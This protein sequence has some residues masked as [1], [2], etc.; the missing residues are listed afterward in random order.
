MD[1]RTITIRVPTRDHT[2]HPVRRRRRRRRLHPWV[3]LCATVVTVLGILLISLLQPD[4]S[5]VAVITSVDP[6]QPTEQSGAY[7]QYYSA[8]TERAGTDGTVTTYDASAAYVDAAGTVATYNSSLV[9]EVDNIIIGSNTTTRELTDA[10]YVVNITH[11]L[12]T[13]F[14]DLIAF[15]SDKGV[16][17]L[18]SPDAYVATKIKLQN[19]CMHVNHENGQLLYGAVG[20]AITVRDFYT[21]H[22][23]EPLNRT[24]WD[25]TTTRDKPAYIDIML[26]KNSDVQ[27]YFAGGDVP[28]QYVQ[29]KVT[30]CKAHTAP[31]GIAQTYFQF[32]VTDGDNMYLYESS[33]GT[34]SAIGDAVAITGNGAEDLSNLLATANTL[35]ENKQYW[36]PTLTATNPR[37]T[38]GISTYAQTYE[39]HHTTAKGNAANVFELYSSAAIADALKERFGDYSVVGVLV[40]AE[41]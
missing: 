9:N 20:P 29:F 33:G 17:G 24:F 26:V 12:T 28:T 3:A 6:S 2:E 14:S 35:G 27:S 21:E 19:M 25:L 38:L 37:D 13:M 34:D 1:Q 41:E 36:W 8:L 5:D 18:E 39:G 23:V 30:D 22:R 16:V 32:D 15:E 31:W 11:L 4:S 40:Y 7:Q 10:A